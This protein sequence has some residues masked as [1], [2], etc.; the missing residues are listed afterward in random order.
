MSYINY[1][2]LFNYSFFIIIFSLPYFN[3]LILLFSSFSIQSSLI[4]IKFGFI[5]NL[6]EGLA[7]TISLGF[8]FLILQFKEFLFSL[9]TFTDSFI[10]SII[11]FTT[12]LHGLHV[13]IGL[14]LLLSYFYYLL[15]F[16]I[17]KSDMSDNQR[18]GPK[19]E[20]LNKRA[21]P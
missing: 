13:I 14:F 16:I 21:K 4:F 1:L 8:L 20:A 17:S 11:Y 7:Q 3:L 6:I 9:F 10:G 5:I 19:G 2:F 12:G 15:F 18:K